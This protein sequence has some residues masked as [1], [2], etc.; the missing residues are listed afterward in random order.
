MVMKFWMG[1]RCVWCRLPCQPCVLQKLSLTDENPI[2]LLLIV[3]VVVGG[4]VIL[5]LVGIFI[6]LYFLCYY[7]PH[8]YSV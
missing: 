2:S 7:Y 8:R 3:C 1:P 5:F 6:G 4:V